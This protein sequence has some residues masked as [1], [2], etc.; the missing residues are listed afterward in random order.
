M[1]SGKGKTTSAVTR[2]EVTWEIRSTEIRAVQDQP[3]L[4]APPGIRGLGQEDAARTVHAVGM[5]EQERIALGGRGVGRPFHG[6][7]AGVAPAVD[8]P[9]GEGLAFHEGRE[10][11]PEGVLGA[12][13]PV[14]IDRLP[15]ML[16]E[17]LLVMLEELLS[18]L[19]RGGA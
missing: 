10:V 6:G 3:R 18:R 2:Y 11:R 16:V 17:L 4:V 8:V 15:G 14:G 9:H 5:L 1:G 12:P 19:L 7:D 13:G